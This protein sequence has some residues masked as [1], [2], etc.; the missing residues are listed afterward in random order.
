MEDVK[1]ETAKPHR[2]HKSG[3][4]VQKLNKKSGN[5]ESDAK[6]RNPRAFAIQS[7]NKLNRSFRHAQDL[8]TK[9]THIPVVD[10]TPTEPPPIVVGIV[11]PPKV[12]KSTLLKGIIKNYCRQPIT[13][14]KGPVTLVTGKTRRLTLIECNNDLTSMID[15]AKVADLILLMMDASYG[16]EMETFE[17]LNICQTHGFPKVMGVLTH[18]DGIKQPKI[19]KKTKKALKHRFWTE[20]YQGAKLFYLSRM[21]YGEYQRMEVKNLCRFISVMKF[22]PLVWRTSHPYMLADRMEDIT[23]PEEIRTDPEC[24][25]KV[26]LYGYVR[27]TSLKQNGIVHIPGAGDF[28]LKDL[29]LLPDPCPFPEKGGVKVRR[30]LDMRERILYAPMSGAGGIVY[31]KD[32]VYIDDN[33]QQDNQKSTDDPGTLLTSSMVDV[34]KTIDNKM[35]ESTVSLLGGH[36]P[37]TTDQAE[38]FYDDDDDD[39]SEEGSDDESENDDQVDDDDQQQENRF[40]RRAKFLDNDDDDQQSE[41][42]DEGCGMDEG[43]EGITDKETSD[44]GEGDSD[45]EDEQIGSMSLNWKENLQEKAKMSYMKRQATT[46]NLRRLVYHTSSSTFLANDEE[47]DEEEKNDDADDE[48]GDGELTGGLFKVNQQKEELTINHQDDYST[49]RRPLT[50]TADDVIMTSIADCFVTGD[51]DDEHDASTLLKQDDELYGDFED[52][53][54]GQTQDD[55]KPDN[56]ENDGDDDMIV[57]EKETKKDREE[58]QREKRMERKRKLKEAFDRNYDT[59]RVGNA[60]E[61]T[62]FDSVKK[63]FDEQARVNREEFA[64]MDDHIRVQYEGFRSGLYVRAELHDVPCEFVTKFDPTYPVILGGV[65]SNETAM[66]FL[67]VRVKRHRW[68]K[69]ILK[70]KDPLMLS[71][72]WRRIQTKPV[73]FMEDHNMRQRMLKYTPEHMHCWAVCWAPITPQVKYW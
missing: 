49:T 42:D 67:K 11:G 19:L 59:D 52:L 69:R 39:D 56:D 45:D 36:E 57:Q 63:D 18:L 43:E 22:R 64:S 66:G 14:I 53:E 33:R 17:F 31:D 5:V 61:V 10:R 8:K 37:I 70:T 6:L 21:V 58:K 73:Y 41:S 12:G 2:K 35:L 28:Q 13:H 51:W 68:F 47:S 71:I 26:T 29:S 60:N 65:L 72:G 1:S 62:T 23:D 54:T 50:Y 15:L 48:F 30:T 3:K 20:L 27:G 55:V 9:K 24:K 7:A 34:D 25:R 16:F 44:E 40:R 38:N 46:V 32:A 4:K